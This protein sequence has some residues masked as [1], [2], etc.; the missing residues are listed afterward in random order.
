MVGLLLRR[1]SVAVL[2]EFLIEEE[3]EEERREVPAQQ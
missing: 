1:P 2:S 3:E